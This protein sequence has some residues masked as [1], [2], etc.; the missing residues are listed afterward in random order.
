MFVLPVSYIY[1][2][3]F[4]NFFKYFIVNRWFLLAAIFSSVV[5]L[6]SLENIGHK[7]CLKNS[8]YI[9]LIK[10]VSSFS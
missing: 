8:P 4:R 9:L 1:V 5:L 3:P 7:S 6:W 2:L 10:R